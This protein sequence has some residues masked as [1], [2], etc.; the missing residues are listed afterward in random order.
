MGIGRA[1]LMQMLWCMC[2]VAGIHAQVPEAVRLLDEGNRL[3]AEGAFSEAL[4]TYEAALGHGVVSGALF[5]NM[6]NAYYRLDKF[7]QALRHYEKAHRILGD[8]PQLLHNLQ[9]VGTQVGTPFS[10]LPGPFWEA[11]WKKYVVRKGPGVFFGLGGL[12]YV[13]AAILFG[14]RI[15][16]GIRAAWHRRA[17]AVSLSLGILLIVVAFAVSVDAVRDHRA[18]VIVREASLTDSLDAE[19]DAEVTVPEG[20][21]VD[22]LSTQGD[23]AEVR[24]PNGVTGYLPRPAIGKI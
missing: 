13:I 17:L 18:V 19:V 21:I 11:P 1:V 8:D 23:W 16:T 4:E 20:V 14:H 10:A 22:V 7:G 24:L 9:T 15:W 5:H 3:Y 12:L 6:G 2:L